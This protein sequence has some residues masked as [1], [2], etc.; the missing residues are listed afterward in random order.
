MLYNWTLLVIT[1]TN[2]VFC[3][4][5]IRQGKIDLGRILFLF[6]KI[7]QPSLG[8]M[9]AAKVEPQTGILKMILML[10]RGIC[11]LNR[12]NFGVQECILFI[13]KWFYRSEMSTSRVFKANTNCTE[14]EYIVRIL[15]RKAIIL[16]SEE[17]TILQ[18]FLQCFHWIQRLPPS[19]KESLIPPPPTNTSF[20]FPDKNLH[21]MPA[22]LYLIY[23]IT[24]TESDMKVGLGNY[25]HRKHILGGKRKDFEGCENQSQ[26]QRKIHRDQ[27]YRQTRRCQCHSQGRDQQ[28]AQAP[29]A[30]K[31]SKNRVKF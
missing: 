18:F 3:G 9:V 24:E 21:Q 14:M 4:Q 20:F 27:R 29:W 23:S 8:S 7:A 13:C 17:K 16:K 26:P 31:N 5:G 1:E 30:R 2:L 19:W 25:I 10:E 22:S 6:F 28:S 11:G 12:L 15:Q